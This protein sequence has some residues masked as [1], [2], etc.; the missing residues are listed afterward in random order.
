MKAGRELVEP[1]P[2]KLASLGLR[3]SPGAICM[4]T[5]SCSSLLRVSINVLVTWRLCLGSWGEGGG[6]SCRFS[7]IAKVGEVSSGAGGRGIGVD[8]T[9]LLARRKLGH[10]L[11]SSLLEDDRDSVEVHAP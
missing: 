10:C 9:W 6:S 1:M 3:N 4:V 2:P 5:L 7:E 11:L 8:V